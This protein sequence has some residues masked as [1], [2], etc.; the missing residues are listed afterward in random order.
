MKSQN[1]SRR[2]L[3][4][5][6]VLALELFLMHPLLVA[7]APAKHKQVQRS[8]KQKPAAE[9][10]WDLVIAGGTVVT[11]DTPHRIFEN[12]IVVVQGDAIVAVEPST[13]AG[14]DKYVHTA[15]KL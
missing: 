10:I 3:V 1:S 14:I 13:S 8:T 6:A 2:K 9:P 15:K 4:A 5:L 11:M 7:Q 12:G